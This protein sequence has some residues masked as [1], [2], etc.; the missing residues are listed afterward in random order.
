MNNQLDNQYNHLT[1]TVQPIQTYTHF[2]FQVNTT[3]SEM[4]EFEVNL[5]GIAKKWLPFT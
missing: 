4:Q 1:S 5:K 2:I 3:F